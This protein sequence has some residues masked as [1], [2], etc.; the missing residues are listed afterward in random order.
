MKTAYVTR[1]AD[2][3]WEA[4]VNGQVLTS[5]HESYM[6]KAIRRIA[7]KHLEVV[8]SESDG[9]ATAIAED[10]IASRFSINQ[11]F[12]FMEQIVSMVA[13]GH[14]ASA[15]VTGEGGL[16]KSYTVYEVLGKRGYVDST[17]EMLDGKDGQ[18]LSRNSFVVMRGFSTAKG[19]YRTL[20][21][22]NGRIIVFDD[23]D[24]ILKDPVALNLLKGALDSFD[25]RIISWNADMRDEDLPKCFEFT[26]RVVFISNITLLKIDQ[27]LRSR[28]MTVDLS[29][30]TT[31]K[32]DRMRHI[33]QSPKFMP[34]V[35]MALKLEALDFIDTMKD[36][37]RELNLR[38]LISVTK[39]RFANEHN[40]R[41]LAE[42]ML[43]K[44]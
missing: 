28:S 6:K 29:M 42:Y 32:I 13:D 33:V 25:R 5:N 2:G 26:G 36:K 20:F 8:F 31:E 17:L 39:I 14:Q 34:K 30:N 44:G 40:W 4:T 21:E 3:K 18:V 41:N 27:A 16:G 22:N 24:S 11:R 10:S 1:N 9:G 38:T 7:G 19:L 35:A 37:C 43:V 15:L 12:D 23:Y